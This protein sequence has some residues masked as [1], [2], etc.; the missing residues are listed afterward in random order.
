[1]PKV[2]QSTFQPFAGDLGI[3]LVPASLPFFQMGSNVVWAK[4]PYLGWCAC[5]FSLVKIDYRL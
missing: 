1:M 3:Q 2:V 4:M 5:A